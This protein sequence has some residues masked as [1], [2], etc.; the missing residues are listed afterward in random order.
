MIA[1]LIEY[2]AYYVITCNMFTFPTI[3]FIELTA[4][5]MYVLWAK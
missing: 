3:E 5:T 4:F 2:F 1:W